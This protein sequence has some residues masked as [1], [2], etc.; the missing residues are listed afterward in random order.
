[1]RDPTALAIANPNIRPVCCGAFITDSLFPTQAF[2]RT[3]VESGYPLQWSE[4]FWM[5][6]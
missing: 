5:K 1:M 6:T 2:Q 4:L 3:L